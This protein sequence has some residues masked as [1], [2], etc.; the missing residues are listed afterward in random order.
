MVQAANA[1]PKVAQAEIFPSTASAPAM[2]SVGT[3]GTGSPICSSSVLAKTSSSPYW[4]MSRLTSCTLQRLADQPAQLAHHPA[5]ERQH[6]DHEDHALRHRHPGAELGEIV[7]HR[8]DDERAHH[9]TEHRAQAAEQHH[10][11]HFARH[12]P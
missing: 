9:R 2:I 4:A 6:A 1:A 3:A 5:A 8:D 10:E 12:G 7:F 11:D